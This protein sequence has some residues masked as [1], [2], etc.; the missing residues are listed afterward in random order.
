[1]LLLDARPP[2]VGGSSREGVGATA[3]PGSRPSQ[4]IAL[5]TAGTTHAVP[6]RRHVS[7]IDSCTERLGSSIREHRRLSALAPGPRLGRSVTIQ[8]VPHRASEE[9]RS[10]LQPAPPFGCGGRF[11]GGLREGAEFASASYCQRLDGRGGVHE[12]QPPL[13]IASR[14]R[15]PRLPGN[16]GSSVGALAGVGRLRILRRDHHMH[17]PRLSV[18]IASDGRARRRMVSPS[19]QGLTLNS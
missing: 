2:P 16:R 17:S 7:R 13:T 3:P 4:C 5:R 11:P 15:R 18:G 8:R 9:G 1:M 19:L 10:A 12:A 6:T 14:P